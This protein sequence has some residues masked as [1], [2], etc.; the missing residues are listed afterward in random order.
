MKSDADY[1]EKEI[2]QRVCQY[3]KQLGVLCYKF[4][5][6]SKRSVP[7]RIYLTPSGL[8]FFIEFKRKNCRPTPAQELEIA[9]IRKQ[10]VACFVVSDVATGKSIISDMVHHGMTF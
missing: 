5:S 4:L 10:K 2:E 1:L 7:D 3:A 6:Q 9:K 8:V